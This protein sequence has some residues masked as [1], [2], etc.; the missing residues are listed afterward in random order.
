MIA[1]FSHGL[2]GNPCALRR[3]DGVLIRLPVRRWHAP[4]RGADRWLLDRCT[5]P[6][7]DLGCGPGRLVTALAERGLPAL[8][9]DI[10]AD[11]VERTLFRGGTALRRDAL[12]RLP[13]EGRWSHVLLADGNIGIGGDPAQLLRRAKVLLRPKGT[14][15]LELDPIGGLWRGAG[16]LEASGVVGP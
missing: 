15:L 11:A 5:G 9:V 4:A 10:S 6:T 7:L 8:G 16:R 13:A 14:V 2:R 1:D 12:G 3:T